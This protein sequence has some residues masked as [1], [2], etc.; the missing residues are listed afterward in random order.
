M[1]GSVRGPTV[2]SVPCAINS[3]TDDCWARALRRDVYRAD[4]NELCLVE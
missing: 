4:G 2:N 3:V 1:W